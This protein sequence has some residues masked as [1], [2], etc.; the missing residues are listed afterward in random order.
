MEPCNDYQQGSAGCHGAKT[1]G[2]SGIDNPW[3]T[4]LGKYRSG[5]DCH[6]IHELEETVVREKPQETQP[7]RY[8]Q[9]KFG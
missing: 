3:E 2:K 7:K 8:N 4:P 6:A 9:Q 1:G 5:S